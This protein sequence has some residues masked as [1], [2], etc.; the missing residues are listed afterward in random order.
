MRVIS[1]VSRMIT[2]GVGL[3][4][5][6]IILGT[7]VVCAIGGGIYW[8]V[9]SF[10]DDAQD[11]SYRLGV[12]SKG[13]FETSISG[14][15]Q[16]ESS[17]QIDIHPK[18]SGEVI[19]VGIKVGDIVHAGQALASIDDSDLQQDIIDAKLDIQ[20]AQLQLDKDIAEAPIDYERAVASLESAH[21][22]LVAEYEGVFTTLSNTFLDLPEVMTGLYDVLLGSDFGNSGQ[23][24]MSYYSS[25][26]D[27]SDGVMVAHLVDIAKDDYDVARVAY[28]E[29]FLHFKE[30]TRSSDNETM[31]AL[32][33][34]TLET[35]KAIA[36]AAK[37]DIN[38]LD[39]VIDVA[40]Q[41]DD[42]LESGVESFES[43]VRGYLSTTNND[44]SS[45]LSQQRALQN[46][47]D[48]ITDLEQDLSLLTINNPSGDTPISLQISKNA[49]AK[50]KQNLA[51][52][53][54][55][56]SDYVVYAPFAGVVASID[57]TRGDTLS[58]NDSVATLITSQ[59]IA[60]I[61]LNEVDAVSV[62]VGQPVVIT[63]DA[64]DGLS[65]GGEVVE[66]SPLATVSQGVVT[67]DVTIAF[68]ESDERIKP[69]MSM[70]ASIVTYSESNSLLVS[71]TAIE[72]RGDHTFVQKQEE[73]GNIVL[74]P[75]ELGFSN[76]F[77]SQV[78][79]GLEEGDTIV[80]SGT[81]PNSTTQLPA[82]FRESSSGSSSS[83]LPIGGGTGVP[84][85][86]FF[87]R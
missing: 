25:M 3:F 43:D 59:Y 78:I 65:I 53:Q 81:V 86:Q 79:S 54:T 63:F 33:D 51:D 57:V 30:L 20:E 22:D 50:K 82:T 10:S 75:V 73:D 32:L 18:A 24:N 11:V 4:R 36:Q 7:I 19:W 38:L 80:I 28:D 47:K 64:I 41:R 70:S 67:Y 60:Q 8:I 5:A 61:A 40:H 17:D 84:R 83:I 56:L 1:F 15:G 74:V 21:N 62:A 2:G 85:G 46:S 16:V 12:V 37:S 39:T 13:A 34:E 26:F 31:E 27:D 72:Y 77:F 42:R 48:D 14:T 9:N 71:N 44:L 58:T 29:T 68:N 35:T 6:H 49:I 66:V 52:L 45:L 69:G 55:S 23:R 76:D 87:S